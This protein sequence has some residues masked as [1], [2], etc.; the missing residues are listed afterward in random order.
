[1]F[2]FKSTATVLGD[3]DATAGCT[4]ETDRTALGT[5]LEVWRS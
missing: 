1:M 4:V 3:A 5:L 2:H